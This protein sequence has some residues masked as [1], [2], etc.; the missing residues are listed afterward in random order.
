MGNVV[1]NIWNTFTSNG[2]NDDGSDRALKGYR[3]YLPFRNKNEFEIL[4]D[5]QSFDADDLPDL[6]SGKSYYLIH[7]NIVK[8]N[9][10][11]SNGETMN[12]LGV[13]SKQNSSND[14]I[15]SVDGVENVNTE[16]KVITQIEMVI[17]NSDGTIVP[18]SVIGKNSGF[19]LMIEKN[20]NP[21][22][23]VT[24]ASV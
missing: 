3:D 12:L 19:I 11:D 13:M 23:D 18:D 6:N 1:T 5:S 2:K 7:S 8:P 15:Y 9:G 20:I 22:T 14:T 21:E 4:C 16:E 17:K 10:L 24:M